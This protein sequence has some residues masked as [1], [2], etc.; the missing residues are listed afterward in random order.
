MA[1][2]HPK[3]AAQPKPK[4][5]PQ[6]ADKVGTR[7]EAV[8]AC[9]H[10]ENVHFHL[11]LFR[12]IFEQAVPQAVGVLREIMTN[13]RLPASMRLKAAEAIIGWD[14]HKLS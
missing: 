13:P 14:A 5:E 10:D 11:T 2:Q 7:D 6:P 3:K 4:P 8:K 9:P 1:K 12:D